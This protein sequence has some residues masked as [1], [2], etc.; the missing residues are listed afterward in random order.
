MSLTYTTAIG[1]MKLI[2]RGS[3]TG[4]LAALGVSDAD[5]ALTT[6]ENPW[7][8]ADRHRVRATLDALTYGSMDLA[9]VPRFPVPAEYLAAIL[10]VFVHSSNRMVASRWA[11]RTETASELAS[12]AGLD[13][14]RC[15]AEQIYSLCIQLASAEQAQLARKAF[16]A[17]TNRAIDWSMG[18]RFNDQPDPNEAHPANNR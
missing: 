14:E 4:D 18:H 2:E 15:T 16:E 5:W 7:C 6:G 17:A 1:A 3:T 12:H 13:A 8:A 9:G 11:E 10:T